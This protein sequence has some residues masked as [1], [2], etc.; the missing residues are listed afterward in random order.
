MQDKLLELLEEVYMQQSNVYKSLQ[1]TDALS[2]DDI[3]NQA[4]ADNNM[5]QAIITLVN[6]HA[7]PKN[8][9]VYEG[10]IDDYIYDKVDVS[11][12][13]FSEFLNTLVLREVLTINKVLDLICSYDT[14][15]DIFVTNILYNLSEQEQ[16]IITDML[17]SLCKVSQDGAKKYLIT[18]I[19]E[20]MAVRSILKSMES[21]V[22][23]EAIY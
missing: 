16:K 10:I 18:Q 1:N 6:N 11:W 22:S 17:V 9:K 5:G 13:D 8:N 7:T 23:R 19:S 2:T 4:I 14:L 20:N 21:K 15:H 12:H 3:E